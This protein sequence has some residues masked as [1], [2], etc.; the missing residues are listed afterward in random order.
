[1]QIRKYPVFY[2]PWQHVLFAGVGAWGGVALVE[3][4]EKTTNEVDELLRKRAE[5]NKNLK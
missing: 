4:T 5:L 2:Q 1:M 3:W